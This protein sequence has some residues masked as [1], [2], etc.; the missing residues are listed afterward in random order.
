MQSELRVDENGAGDALVAGMLF[1]LLK[2]QARATRGADPPRSA[3]GGRNG[4]ERLA[5]PMISD[6]F[7]LSDPVAEALAQAAPVVALESTIITHGLAYPQNLATARA[8]EA[9][10]RAGG[11]VPATIAIL[12]GRVRIGLSDAEL[13]FLAEAKGCHKVSRAD[14]A[15]MLA[16]GKAGSTTVA[17]TAIAAHAAGISVFA[18]GGIGGVHRGGEAT[19]DIS[20]DLDELACTPVVVVSAGAK[21]ILDLPKTLEVLETRG[22]PV[23]GYRTGDFPAFWSRK[24]GLAVPIRVDSAAEIAGIYR[25]QRRLNLPAGLLVANPVAE[26]DEIPLDVMARFI[27]TAQDRADAACVRGK[28]VTPFLLA[29]IAELSD[30]RSVATNIAL[31]RNNAALGA[32]IAREIAKEISSEK[33]G[34]TGPE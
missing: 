3:R 16:L 8:V 32:E 6:L 28:A 7:V 5:A 19:F 4:I 9:S 13:V 2:G 10:V 24:S 12:E 17:A 14:F 25:M 18:T 30:G 27:E 26:A 31:I 21:A 1:G 34:R 20:A 22:V 11:A 33:V 29:Q 15:A 23:L